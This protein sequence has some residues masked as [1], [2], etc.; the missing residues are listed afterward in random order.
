MVIIQYN[1]DGNSVNLARNPHSM[2]VIYGWCPLS[3]RFPPRFGA[4]LPNYE[5]IEGPDLSYGLT[6]VDHIVNNVPNLFDAVDYLCGYTGFHQFGEFTAED[7]GTVDSGLNSMVLAN[8]AETV[9][10]PKDNLKS[11]LI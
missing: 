1:T 10:V 5:P 4:F 3:R 7:V 9:L 11:K 2:E 6:R 8:N